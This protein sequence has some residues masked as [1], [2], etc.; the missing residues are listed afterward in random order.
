[1]DIVA[2]AFLHDPLCLV[3][4]CISG[5]DPLTPLVLL[6]LPVPGHASWLLH[7]FV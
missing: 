5:Y 2:F 3:G 6:P 4:R 7:P 1:M